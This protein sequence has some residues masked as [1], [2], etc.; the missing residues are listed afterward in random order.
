VRGL[1]SVSYGERLR[2]LDL[3]SFQARLLHADL[4]LVWK[5]FNGRCALKPDDLFQLAPL[6]NTRGHPLNIFVP[7]VGLDIHT[8]FF[9]YI[10]INH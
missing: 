10:M 5:I 2:H 7:R 1:E 4:I 8:R 6:Q 9:S 3:F